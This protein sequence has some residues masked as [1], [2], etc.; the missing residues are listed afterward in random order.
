MCVA[1]NEHLAK[2]KDLLKAEV[3]TERQAARENSA[4]VARLKDENAALLRTKVE[5][6]RERAILEERSKVLQVRS[7]WWR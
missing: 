5:L 1:A 7:R 6:E 4:L 2:E 3:D